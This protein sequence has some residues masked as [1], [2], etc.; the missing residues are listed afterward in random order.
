M[1]SVKNIDLNRYM[2]TQHHGQKP[3]FG[4]RP[5]PIGHHP[6]HA[7]VPLPASG[8]IDRHRNA[9]KA[10]HAGVNRAPTDQ[11]I[12][13]T[14]NQPG[15]GNNKRIKQQRSQLQRRSLGLIRRN[16]HKSTANRQSTHPNIG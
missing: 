9:A 13:I 7:T 12:E 16:K 8:L 2:V 4:D 10:T 14:A 5:G 3:R 11:G 15:L 1:N 6:I